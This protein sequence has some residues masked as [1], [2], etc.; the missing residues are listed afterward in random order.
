MGQYWTITCL[1]THESTGCLRELGEALYSSIPE[2][3]EQLI[4]PSKFALM[5]LPIKPFDEPKILSPLE[6]L[7]QETIERIFSFIPRSAAVFCF[8]LTCHRFLEIGRQA[9]AMRKKQYIAPWAGKRIICVGNCVEG[10]PENV[11]TEKEKAIMSYKS[12][13][14]YAAGFEYPTLLNGRSINN[15][16]KAVN[17][18]HYYVSRRMQL[19]NWLPTSCPVS[20]DEAKAVL[21]NITTNEYVRQSKIL[22][23]Y[24]IRFGHII[25]LYASWTSDPSAATH[26]EEEI[27]WRPWAGHRFEITFI[28]SVNQ[29]ATDVSDIIVPR[30]KSIM[31][32]SRG[33][34]E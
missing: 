7:P 22:P 12:L 34:E 19:Q 28:D 25:M 5:P 14:E 24:G 31:N 18:D 6:M 21:L 3:I 27:H 10:Y 15:I 30:I 1:D 11:L 16:L 20:T 8:A 29:D 26:C 23:K 17:H 2:S 9:I 13:Y 4:I 33:I 32:Q